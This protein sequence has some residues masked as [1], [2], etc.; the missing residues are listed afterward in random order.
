MLEGTAAQSLSGFKKNIF[1]NNARLMRTHFSDKQVM[2]STLSSSLRG[3]LGEFLPH[4]EQELALRSSE[5]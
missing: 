2:I 3:Y 5:V 4:A 1:P